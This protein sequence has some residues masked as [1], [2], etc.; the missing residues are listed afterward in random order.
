MT[1][2]GLCGRNQSDWPEIDFQL[3]QA[4]KAGVIKMMTVTRPSVFARLTQENPDA[5][6][7]TRL[8]DDRISTG[9]IVTPKQFAEKMTPL[10]AEL[11]PHCRD[12]Q[13][14][15]EPNHRDGIEGWGCDD[16][17]AVNFA[18]WFNEVY[19][20]LKTTFPQAMF[21]FPGL[22]L[23]DFAHRDWRWLTLCASAI[24][25]ADWLGCHCYWQSPPDRDSVINHPNFGKN[26]EEYHRVYPDKTIHI[27]EC[28]NSNCQNNY[29]LPDDQQAEEYVTWSSQL[30]DYVASASF[31]IASSPDPTWQGFS[32]RD[33]SR[34]KP[35][36]YRLAQLPPRPTKEPVVVAS[37]QTDDISLTNQQIINI[38]S[39]AAYSLG[40]EQWSILNT[41]KLSL[42][43]LV[44]DRQGVYQGKPLSSLTLPQLYKD[45]L[46][47]QIARIKQQDQVQQKITGS[48]G[49]VV[50]QIAGQL[51]LDL[52]VVKA[53]FRV[54][55][56]GSGFGPGGRVKIRFENHIFWDEWGVNNAD[57]FNAHFKYNKKQRWTGHKWRPDGGAWQECHTSQDV[58]YQVLN[59]ASSLNDTAAL[60][61]ISMGLG[62]IMGFNHRAAGYDTVQQMFEA[63][64]DRDEQI[65]AFFRFVV[66]D[67]N[68]LDA[69]KNK[70]WRKFALHYNGA[71]NVDAYSEAYD[72][73]E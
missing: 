41:A 5:L 7:I 67:G 18:S 72:G 6:I 28:G 1:K 60:L 34:F 25:K 65:R 22:A 66:A 64:Q 58:E 4:M 23:P 2:I 27:L 14:H 44:K 46:D 24:Q 52:D 38:F 69:M 16:A 13:I 32:F 3:I 47:L 45:A 30:P 8:Y 40:I 21:G 61:S 51:G 9:N 10:I 48:D 57:I 53:V 62:Q 12:F 29:P 71:G 70:D 39:Q 11:L 33:G 15:N 37:P 55:A 56:G 42:T 36:V 26:Y 63:M 19:D 31:F 17:Q 49:D 73:V 35:V 54:E 68:R 43:E 20:I 59:F 50:A